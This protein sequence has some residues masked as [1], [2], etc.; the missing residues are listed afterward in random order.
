MLSVTLHFSSTIKWGSSSRAVKK[1]RI[2]ANMFSTFHFYKPQ[3]NLRDLSYSFFSLENLMGS[4]Q[5]GGKKH[6]SNEKA[7]VPVREVRWESYAEWGP[8]VADTQQKKADTKEHL[9]YDFIFLLRTDRLYGI[10]IKMM[11]AY[12]STRKLWSLQKF[13]LSWSRRWL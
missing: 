2:N 13:S 6:N 3:G 1:N 7:I 4:W 8:T 10:E 12:E 5:L 9:L 11:V